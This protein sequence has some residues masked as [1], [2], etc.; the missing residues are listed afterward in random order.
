VLG[1]AQWGN[2]YGVTNA[3]GRLTDEALSGIIDAARDAGIGSLDT[4]AAYGDAE[5]RLAPYAADFAITTKVFGDSPLPIAAQF[6]SSLDHL[7][8]THVRACLVHDWSKLNDAQAMAAARQL[9]ELAGAGIVDQVGVS[10][11]DSEDLARARQAFGSLEIAQIPINVLDQ[12]LI[13]DGTLRDLAEHGTRIQA[14]SVLLQGLLAGR[15]ES[16]LGR[17]PDVVRFHD[18]CDDLGCTPIEVALAFIKSVAPVTEVV[19]GVTEAGEL[20]ELTRIWT[21]LGPEL[22][23]GDMRSGDLGLIDPRTWS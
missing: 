16:A 14:R 13:V 21:H 12:R 19:V 17:H 18:K 1:T 2:P 15:S 6:Q 22:R 7:G 5:L 11:Y 9:Q 23:W 20:S 10:A 4:A 3:R 8:V